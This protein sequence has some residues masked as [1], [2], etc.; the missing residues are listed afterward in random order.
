METSKKR[1]Q[2]SE[3]YYTKK[4]EGDRLKRQVQEDE[5]VHLKDIESQCEDFWEYAKLNLVLDV[6]LSNSK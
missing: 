1:R 6:L 4:R 5:L 3:E 2:R